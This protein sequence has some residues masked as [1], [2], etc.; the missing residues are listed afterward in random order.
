MGHDPY[1]EREEWEHSSPD[2]VAVRVQAGGTFIRVSLDGR[3]VLEARDRACPAGCVGLAA[4]GS[5]LFRH[6]KVEGLAAEIPKLWATHEG[7]LPRFSCPGG[8]EF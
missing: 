5:V 3:I 7:E 8:K 4:R 2:W 1:R 6:L